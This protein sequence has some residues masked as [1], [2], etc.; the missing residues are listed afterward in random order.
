MYYDIYSIILVNISS[1]ISPTIPVATRGRLLVLRHSKIKHNHSLHPSN[2]QA[3]NYDLYINSETFIVTSSIFCQ[4]ETK[5]VSLKFGWCWCLCWNAMREKH[6]SFAEKYCWSSAAEH[7][8]SY[9]DTLCICT[10]IPI[11]TH[12]C[13]FSESIC[14]D[15]SCMHAFAT[16]R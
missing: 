13:I 16:S 6:C 2:K 11:Y 1:V 15:S 3:T 12:E 7:D 4:R 14:M 10:F 8:H 5:F 9:K